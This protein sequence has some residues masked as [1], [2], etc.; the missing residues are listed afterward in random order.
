MKR[1]VTLILALSN[2]TKLQLEFK[3]NVDIHAISRTISQFIL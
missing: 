1:V 3:T 2:G